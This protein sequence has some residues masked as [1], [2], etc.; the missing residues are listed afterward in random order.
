M[1]KLNKKIEYKQLFFEESKK[2]LNFLHHFDGNIVEEKDNI[3]IFRNVHTLKAMSQTMGYNILAEECH[4]FEELLKGKNI[5]GREYYIFLEKLSGLIEK[6]ERP[7]TGQHIFQGLNIS[8]DDFEVIINRLSGIIEAVRDLSTKN[9]DRV[10]NSLK[11]IYS[12]IIPGR[13]SHIGVMKKHLLRVI[14]TSQRMNGK[15]V[16]LEFKGEKIVVENNMLRVLTRIMI[17]LVRNAISH[18]IELPGE[19]R[20]SNKSETGIIEVSASIAGRELCIDVRDDGR[21][22]NYESIKKNIADMGIV[23]KEVARAKENEML[24]RYIFYPRITGSRHLD[25]FSG[26]GMGL[27]DARDQLSSVNGTIAVESTQ[28]RGTTFSIRVPTK[29]FSLKLRLFRVGDN[30]IG[31]EPEFITSPPEKILETRENEKTKDS[32]K[33]ILIDLVRYYNRGDVQQ[34]IIVN[35]SYIGKQYKVIFEEEIGLKEL[36]I[37]GQKEELFWKG[38]TDEARVVSVL[39]FEY[40]FMNYG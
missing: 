10:F 33:A 7:V 17:Q 19:R 31:V 21:G 5:K 30:F 9:K 24:N 14:S 15:S 12:R 1:L 36:L 11:E 16:S 40:I 39:N 13:V 23:H 18:G 26:Q 25:E 3:Q 34:K 28:N 20:K 2:I 6:E 32:K 4:K 38:F 27:S 29:V 22:I 35:A 37:L 8:D